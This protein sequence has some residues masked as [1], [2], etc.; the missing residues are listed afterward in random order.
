MEVGRFMFEKW[1][2]REVGEV[3]DFQT[4]KNQ[5]A[6]KCMDMIAREFDFRIL[7]LFS[8]PPP[9]LP[10]SPLLVKLA[11][12]C[13]RTFPVGKL[14]K[15]RQTGM[16]RRKVGRRISVTIDGPDLRTSAGRRNRPIDTRSSKRSRELCQNLLSFF[17]RETWKSKC[18][19]NKCHFPR[20]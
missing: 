1:K 5:K 9:T 20:T 4:R 19:E 12:Q 11:S 7:P 14:S 15:V 16:T 2:S 8:P 18:S 6:R 10:P 13:T 17:F 3:T